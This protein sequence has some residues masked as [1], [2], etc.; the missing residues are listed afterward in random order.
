MVQII[1][2]PENIFIDLDKLYSIQKTVSV[3]PIGEPQKGML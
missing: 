1:S 2:E 3:V